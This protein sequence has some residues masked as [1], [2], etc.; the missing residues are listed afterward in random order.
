MAARARGHV[1]I[2][3]TGGFQSQIASSPQAADAANL[4]QAP[5]KFIILSRSRT[6]SNLLVSLLN[7]HPAIEARGEL[8]Q[9]RQ[10]TSFADLIESGFSVSDERTRAAGFKFFYYHPL[11]ED[12]T[13]IWEIFLGMPHLHVIHLKRR[14]IL[15][16][17]V[18]H[19][20]AMSDNVWQQSASDQVVGRTGKKV[21]LDIEELERVFTGTRAMEAEGDRKFAGHPVLEVHYENLVSD[22]FPTYSRITGFLGVEDWRPRTDLVRQNPEPLSRL[23]ANYEELKEAFAATRWAGLFE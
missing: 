3:A 13:E 6:G 21:T 4:S 20:L 22:T 2:G 10:E 18:S 16:T 14:N 12:P 17:L 7:S 11:R 9:R 19:K 5:T 15:R 23:I 1:H 8:L